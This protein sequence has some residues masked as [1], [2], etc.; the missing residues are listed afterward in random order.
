MKFAALADIHGNS[1]ALEAVLHDMDSLGIK[2]AVNLGDFFSG[3]IDA[4]KTATILM[5]RDFASV[6]GNHDR[7]LIEQEPFS[8]GPSD[9]V[10][11]DQLSEQHLR[12]IADLPTTRIVNDDVF[13]CHA[14]PTSDSTYWLERVEHNGVVRS[15]SLAEV[16]KEA[17]GVQASLILCAH[18]HI[19]RCV[20]LPDGRVIVNPGSVGC[21]AYDD[22]LPYYHHM[23]TGTPNASYALLERRVDEWSITF[24][25]VRY[26][27]KQARD[28]ALRNGRRDW[29]RALETGW[30]EE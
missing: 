15:A 10:A 16:T 28:C 19:P 12:W 18:T 26:D 11:F 5:E 1:F 24:R 20:R 4:A 3:P 13:L 27:T 14:T 29:A 30:F 2:D 22:D 25:S 17:V 6:R 7:Y 21:P 8:M 9:R 23:Q